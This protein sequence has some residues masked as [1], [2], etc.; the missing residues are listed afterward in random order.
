MFLP[1]VAD[2][3]PWPNMKS[4]FGVA[5]ATFAGRQIAYW[6]FF[7]GIVRASAGLFPSKTLGL[8]AAVSYLCEF[9]YFA[10][11]YGKDT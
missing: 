6:V 9:S 8:L 2:S 3:W 11:E 10:C 5:P 1:S 4:I 7:H